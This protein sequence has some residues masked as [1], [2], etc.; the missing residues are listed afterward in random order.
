MWNRNIGTNEQPIR[1]LLAVAVIGFSAQ[2][3][4]SL[5]QAIAGYLAGA[6]C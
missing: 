1:I 6:C 2:A 3:H 4:T 5:I